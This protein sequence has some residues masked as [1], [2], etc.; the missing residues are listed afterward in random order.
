MSGLLNKSDIK[1]EPKEDLNSFPGIRAASSIREAINMAKDKETVVI[2]S[3]NNLDAL[4]EWLV[5]QRRDVLVL[6]SGWKDKFNL[7]KVR[8]KEGINFVHK[9]LIEQTRTSEIFEEI[10]GVFVKTKT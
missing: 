7:E 3:L 6:G 2:G 10:K 5:K 8:T 9:A 1:D 4:C